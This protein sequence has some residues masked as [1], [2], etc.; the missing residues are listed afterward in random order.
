MVHSEYVGISLERQELINLNVIF[1]IRGKF[2]IAVYKT[3][4]FY[5]NDFPGCF[6]LTQ[7]VS[8][9]HMYVYAIK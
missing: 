2:L 4:S 9:L 7:T 5:L 3:Y 6:F 1:T 8:Y